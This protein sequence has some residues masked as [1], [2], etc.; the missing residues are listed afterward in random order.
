MP[1]GTDIA[2]ATGSSY[3]LTSSEQGQTIQVQVTFTDDSDNEETLTSEASVA[4]A[5]APNR[6]ATG[7]PTI[8]GTPE[9]EQTLTADTS[10]ITDQDG[11]DNVSWQY[12]WLA[13]AT[14]ISGATGSSYQLTSDEQGKTIQ[15]KA[16]FTD[17][18]G[19]SE[20]LTSEAT[21]VV[22]AK[23]VPL[24]ASFS[25]VPNSHSGS[26]TTFTFDLAFSENFPLSYITLRDHAFS[27]DDDGPVTRA[28]R[29]V[30]GSNQTWTI[31]V[32]PK[33]NVA[34]TL[35]LPATT[36][37]NDSG[38]IC[39]SDGRKLSHSLSFTVSGPNQ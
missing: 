17:D 6:E 19:N 35:T 37:C 16:T 39:T 32:E 11:L 21:D 2:A 3:T 34:I 18:R 12:Q 28:Q 7:A 23:P 36:D 1:A 27:E 29:K 8:N 24:T 10:G 31:T 38:A 9:V 15:V 14:D 22:A 30:Q 25:N 20:S 5:A 33:G 13:G 26:G 4:V